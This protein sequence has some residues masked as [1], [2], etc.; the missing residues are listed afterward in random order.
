MVRYVRILLPLALLLPI[1]CALTA[2]RPRA[3][4]DPLIGLFLGYTKAVNA[5]ALS[6][7]G[8]QALSGGQ[9][10]VL[11]LWDTATGLLLRT[12]DAQTNSINSVAFS[13]DGRQILTGGNDSRV[14]LW[15][16]G[17]G[18]IVKTMEGHTGEVTSIAFSPGAVQALSGSKDKTVKLW[19][20]AA[21]QL[22]KT[23]E[24]HSGEVLS[25]AFSPDGRQVLS[26]S[27]DK[28]LKLWD[29]ETGQLLKT[30]E[31]HTNEVTSAALSPDG[32]QAL[33]GSRDKTVKLWDA[34]AGQPL[35]TFEGHSDEV[36]SVAF[37]PDGRRILSA[38]K[39]K[40]LKLW[41]AGSGE[42]IKTFEGHL[43]G[44]TS[45]VFSSDGRRALSG[46]ADKTLKLWDVEAGQAQSTIDLTS[47]TFSPNGHKAFGLFGFFHGA[48]LPGAPDPAKLNE[49]LKEQGFKLGD[50]VFIRIFKGDL[51]VEL[52]MKRAAR[53]ELFATYP[54]CA[55][56]GQL[57][58]KLQ[59]GDAQAPEG[60][61]TI[62]K[63]QLNPNSHFHRAFNLGYP[64][65]LD[66]AHNRTGA[67]LM[68]HGGCASIG[69]YAMTDPVIDELWQLVTAALDG[70]QERVGV[71]MFPFRMTA[72]RLAAF[73]W[74]PWAEFWQDLK[75]AY[76]LFEE[77][78]VPPQ[79]SV[80]NKRYA[81]HRATAAAGSAPGLQSACPPT[82]ENRHAASAQP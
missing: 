54:I 29:V 38:S 79:I 63:A 67:N 32:R 12:F 41:D 25:V 26:A 15:D 59:E 37:S 47:V 57:G 24:G 42:L 44:V 4:T 51:Q 16:L 46:S 18:K 35:K 45:A 75:P 82:R 7:D 31:G 20:V 21:G 77:T 33:S 27:A 34:A 52:W 14:Q 11:R 17:T 74:H 69:C 8:R 72:Q 78:R 5:A 81:V 58:P 50:P 80:C 36:L 49:R 1:V 56:S 66:R 62:G 64:N 70:G 48:S 9:D 76:D 30:F 71:H 22:L 28:T 2:T 23:F 68:M 13:P 6:A 43:D 60:F 40:T 65:L 53:F 55:W 39:D 19:D 73:G 61:Y 3:Q 10:N